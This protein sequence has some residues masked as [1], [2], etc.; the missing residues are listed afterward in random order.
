[1][2]TIKVI[3]I[4]LS[5]LT[6]LSI[7]ILLGIKIRYRLENKFITAI[8]KRIITAITK[9]QPL[10]VKGL[11]KSILLSETV[12]INEEI[13]IPENILH[14]VRE[15]TR[16][17]YYNKLKKNIHAKDTTKRTQAAMLLSF[18]PG[19]ETEDTL[20]TAL[21][22]EKSNYCSL[23]ICYSLMQLHCT[24]SIPAIISLM[25]GKDP[26]YYHRLIEILLK[27]GQDLENFLC[28]TCR[29]DTELSEETIALICAFVRRF[30]SQELLE[31]LEQ[32]LDSN[33]SMTIAQVFLDKYPS[34]LIK[35]K[36]L[37]HQDTIIRGMAHE[38]LGSLPGETSMQRLINS[39]SDISIRTWII[40][41]IQKMI[42]QDRVVLEKFFSQCEMLFKKIKNNRKSKE[43]EQYKTAGYALLPYFEYFVYSEKNITC[44][45]H[46]ALATGKLSDI[47]TFLETNHN[48]RYEQKIVYIINKYLETNSQLKDKLASY[49]TNENILSKLGL[50]KLPE[51][52]RKP[53]LKL[54][55]KEKSILWVLAGIILSLP[56]L[57]S[58]YSFF[59]AKSGFADFIIHSI[60][61]V[62][63]YISWYYLAVNTI[64]CMLIIL[65][66]IN[67]RKQLKNWNLIRNN[68]VALEAMLP[69]VSIL[70]PAFREELSIVDSVKSLLSLNYPKFE[71]IVICDGSP[72][73]TLLK[74]IEAFKLERVD[75]E[76]N[77][78]IPCRQIR[79]FYANPE[80]PYLLVIDK[81][82]GGKADSL[83]AGINFAKND[84]ICCIDADSLLERDALLRMMHHIISS[85][86]EIIACGG[87]ILPVNG[88]TV[89]SGAL[90][91]IHIPKNTL[92]CFQTVE[93]MRAFLAGRLGWSKLDSLLIISGAFGVFKR[94]KVLEINGY[95][96]GSASGKMDTVGEDM[97]L[98]VRLRRT[99]QEKKKNSKVSYC[100]NANC[101]TEVPEDWGS[102][103]RQRDRWHRG[104]LEILMFHRTCLLKPRYG[105]MGL[106]AMPY[107]WIFEC[108][109]PFFELFSSLL[110]LIGI[111]TGYL[112][113]GLLLLYFTA[114]ILFG[115]TISA[116]SL[117][118]I[119][120]RIVYFNFFETFTL[121]FYSI[122]ENF[123]YRQIVAIKRV[124]S[125][126]KLLTGEGG[127]GAIKRKG[128]SK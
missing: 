114:S 82:N 26:W 28:T 34:L 27:F 48:E 54:G 58:M 121:L 32:L 127:W 45:I 92:A 18:F 116:F 93:Y 84:Y 61:A 128:F 15:H 21:N 66:A 20:L 106:I 44:L 91:R 71:V 111:A 67:I 118:F 2:I 12:K 16:K 113:P 19:S 30:P 94:D 14:T 42:R 83:N 1:M 70:A 6:L 89:A 125:Y 107:F 55:K 109:G 22:Q 8:R 77:S 57:A 3:F 86:K 25:Y 46:I 68:F 108:L 117:V 87:N 75:R 7:L 36:Y 101:W 13:S 49:I 10:I 126:F 88:C 17:K 110:L 33:H 73:N 95:L 105:T 104:L 39:A 119:E 120:F 97:E 35:E 4:T 123:G 60:R 43:Y 64:Y 47:T 102:F 79:G 65:S 53:A 31:E 51:Q 124:F 69:S 103:S 99:A 62:T 74:L 81:L 63:K 40:K 80:Y 122:I 100:Y 98:V 5:L 38:A 78:H 23:Q 115:I 37:T 96:T 90:E 24:K 52:E 59:I 50:R 112:T 29:D 9:K 56:L 11:P 41:G 85:E 72:D 76:P